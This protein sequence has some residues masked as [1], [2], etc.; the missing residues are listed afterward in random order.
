MV[1]KVKIEVKDGD[2]YRKAIINLEELV[3]FL[4]EELA[5]MGEGE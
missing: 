1:L 2:S 4:R 5:K 3:D